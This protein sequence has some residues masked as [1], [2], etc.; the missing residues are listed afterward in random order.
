[1]PVEG[2]AVSIT[3]D[4]QDLSNTGPRNRQRTPAEVC[5]KIDKIHL[6]LKRLEALGSLLVLEGGCWGVEHFHQ[7]KGQ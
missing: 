4:S 7:D 5:V 1:M 6:I 2:A 3:L